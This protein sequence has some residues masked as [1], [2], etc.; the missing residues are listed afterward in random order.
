MRV[1]Y[2]GLAASVLL[3]LSTVVGAGLHCDCLSARGL[4]DVVRRLQRLVGYDAVD[5]CRLSTERVTISER[6]MEGSA[7]RS[8]W[9]IA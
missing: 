1:S 3:G 9:R 2:L 4:D 5:L 7:M 6:E 8:G